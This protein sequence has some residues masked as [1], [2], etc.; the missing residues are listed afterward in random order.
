MPLAYGIHHRLWGAGL[1]HLG[2]RPS[3]LDRGAALRGESPST[4]PPSPGPPPPSNASGSIYT[5]W[6]VFGAD[7]DATGLPGDERLSPERGRRTP[8]IEPLSEESG[9]FKKDELLRPGTL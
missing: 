4:S 3:V 9:R 7:G 8:E 1:A 2:Q 6:S 5:D